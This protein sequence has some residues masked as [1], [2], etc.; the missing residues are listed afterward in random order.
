M[1]LIHC[2][3][4]HL[5]SSLGTNFDD[6]LARERSAEL[7]YTF[8][9][10]AAYARKNGVRAVLIAGDLFDTER[11]SAATGAFVLR[12]VAD[13]PEVDFLYL[14]GN[15]EESARA[16]AGCAL[17]PNLKTFSDTWSYYSY[18]G[19]TVAGCELHRG[20]ALSLYDS[21]SLPED[22]TNIVLLHGQ[23]SAQPGEDLIALPL[24]QNRG[25]HYLALG[26]LHSYRSGTLDRTGTY[27]YS[28]CLEGRGFDE[29]GEKGFVLLEAA[30]GQV[31]AQFVPFAARRAWDL[32]VDISGLTT[33]PELLGAMRR[34]AEDIPEKDLVRFALCGGCTPETQ[35]DF[36]FL[37]AQLAPE[38]Y[39]VRI[40]D[41]SRL[42]VAPGSYE[43]DVS[44]KGAFVRLVLASDHTDAEKD[45]MIRSG[46]QAL[47]G[48]AITL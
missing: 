34:A 12:T 25:I 23:E 14:R 38:H 37:R 1:K 3:D 10:L 27:A 44:L 30:Q 35:K 39:L 32:S 22:T 28:G 33:A 18:D 40:R 5:D 13:T 4:L 42:A 9:R 29:C 26:H 17:P 47:R 31:T 20:N 16:F 15:H 45:A 7:C 43:N 2:S 41:E 36:T 19:V 6:R 11:V 8:A 46:L 48:E 24:L 21:L